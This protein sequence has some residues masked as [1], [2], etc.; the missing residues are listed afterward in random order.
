MSA[1]LFVDTSAFIALEE[2]D[3]ENHASALAFAARIRSGEWGETVTSSYVLAE[4]MAWF[5]RDAAKKV[6]MGTNLQGGSVRL[7]WVDRPCVETA[8]NL[9]VRRAHDPFSLTDVTS[10]VL[11]DRLGIRDVFTF[12]TD[13]DRLGRYRRLPSAE[14]KPATGRPERA[15]R[16]RRSHRRR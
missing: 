9:L 14:A 10:F 5:S 7:E 2:E 13:F 12:D 1:R 16:P 8:W 11:M 3:D 15:A 6:E 4:L